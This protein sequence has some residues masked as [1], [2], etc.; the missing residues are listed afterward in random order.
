MSWTLTTAQVA[1]FGAFT[2]LISGAVA[3]LVSI[4]ISRREGR[5]TWSLRAAEAYAQGRKA[6]DML[7]PVNLDVVGPGI[8]LGYFKQEGII[9]RVAQGIEAA[10]L[11]RIAA[12]T[13]P[14]AQRPKPLKSSPAGLTRWPML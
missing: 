3:S 7:P 11:L 13:A 4:R 6:W 8:Q 5:R 14:R 9:Q 1:L 12:V 2:T 10:T